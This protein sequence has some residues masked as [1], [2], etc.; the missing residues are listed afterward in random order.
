MSVEAPMILSYNS[1]KAEGCSGEDVLVV[2]LSQRKTTKL[3][4]C[5]RTVYKTKTAIDSFQLLK[6]EN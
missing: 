1:L 2:K 5:F 4:E 3:L 6:L